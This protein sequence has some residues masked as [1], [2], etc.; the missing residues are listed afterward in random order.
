MVRRRNPFKPSFGVSPPLLVGRD[1]LRE[2]FVDALD[3]GPGSPSRAT[4]YTGARGVGK[5]VMLNAVEDDARERGWLVASQTATPGLIERLVSEQLPALLQQHDPEATK[6]RLTGVAVP[7]GM[8]GL[9]WD[10]TD[11]HQAA[12]GLRTQIERLSIILQRNQTG[13]LI[14]VDELHRDLI[15]E[16]IQLFAVIQ[17]GFRE[18]L[19][20]AFAGAGLPSAVTGLLN[21]HVLTFLRRAERHELG[22]VSSSDVA[23]AL[24]KP[25]ED[26]E[27]TIS[28]VALGLAVKATAGYPFMIQLVGYGIWRQ[29]PD[30]Q[31]ITEADVSAGTDYARRRLGSLVH[32]PSLKAC[33]DIDWTFLLAMARDDG[34]SKTS[35]IGERMGANKNFVSQYRLRLISASLIEPAGRGRVTFTLPYLREYLREHAAIKHFA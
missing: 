27:R 5:T 2:E 7:G 28:D 20:L 19:E 12:A 26:N 23:M 14:T 10:T 33:S 30:R 17:H 13:L 31:A 6:R 21:Q 16:L 24:K 34:P 1:E 25:I 32:E 9:T 29:R 3:N 35:D 18:E 15:D 8:G 4:L 11:I 22:V